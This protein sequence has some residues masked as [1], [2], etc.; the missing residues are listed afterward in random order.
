MGKCSLTFIK[1]F[2]AFGFL[3]FELFFN[4]SELRDKLGWPDYVIKTN[5]AAE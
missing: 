5:M 3:F 1:T 4:L 2:K